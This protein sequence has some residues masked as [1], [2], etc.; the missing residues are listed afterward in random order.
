MVKMRGVIA[1]GLLTVSLVGWAKTPS[2]PAGV[3]QVTTVE[4]VTEY[5]LK[6]GLQVILA[7]DSSKPTTTVNI[8]Y[9]VGSRME[10]YGETGMA[11]LLEH[12][13]FKGTPKHPTIAADLSHR[14][15]RPNGTTWFDRTNYFE[16]FSASED[17]LSWALAMEAD[18]M[19]NS[20][21][22]RKDLDSEMTVVRNEM[23]KDE[24][25]ASGI[26]MDKLMATAY[27]WHNYGKS[28]IG[29]RTDVENVSIPHLQAFYHKYYQPDNATLVVA[30]SFD[31][32][33]TLALINK[34]FGSIPK[35]KRVIEP[36]YTLDPVQDGEREVTLRR[37]GDVKYV[38]AVYHSVAAAHPD[39]AAF[40]I[41][42]YIMG[43]TPSGRLHKALVEKGLATAVSA[44][45]FNLDEPGVIYFEA[46]LSKEQSLDKAKAAFIDTIE[47]IHEHPI[48][49]QEVE[50]AKANLLNDITQTFN[51]PESFGISLSTAIANG[52]WRLF[53]LNRDRIQ[54]ITTQDVERVAETWFKSSNRTLGEF[55]PTAKPDRVPYAT[56]VDAKEQLKGYTGNK[57]VSQAEAFDV[58][59][60]NI[61]KRTEWGTLASGV[62]YALLPKKT[63]GSTVFA[64]LNLHFGDANNLKDKSE[65]AKMVAGLLDRGTDK[66]TR[67]Q[68][69]DRF[70]E[71]KAQVSI[72]GGPTGVSVSVLTDRQHLADTLSLV[73]D[74]LRH[75]SFPES[76]FKQLQRAAIAT[77]EQERTD[78][79]AIAGNA[80]SRHFNHY[81]KGDVRYV[82]TF[83]E[84][85]T[86]V[87]AITLEQI[88]QFYHDFYGANRGEFAVVGDFDPQQIK[89]VLNKGLDQWS[90]AA[91][92]ELVLNEYQTPTALHEVINTPDKA[93][94]VFIMKLSLP[95][96][97]DDPSAPALKVANTIF[98]GGFLSSRLATRIRQK[99]GISYGV[100][101]FLRLN[102]KTKNSTLGAYAIYAPQNLSR[103]E[104]AFKEETDKALKDGFSET[105]VKEAKQSLRQSA[106]LG[107]AQDDAL[108]GLLT[109]LLFDNHDM[110][111]VEKMDNDLQQVSVAEANQ[112]FKKWVTP[113]SFAEVMAGDFNKHPAK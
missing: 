40:K 60:L 10:N 45:S 33:K 27:Q 85:E 7:P 73:T 48:T 58:S 53:F 104:Q 62:R 29:A 35:P 6:N 69:S 86:D 14:G 8:T 108:A 101:S 46:D 76:E 16:T 23:E 20:F 5:R 97:E 102:D 88:K 66:L 30:G 22:A 105:E 13:M 112:A 61:Q 36:T 70:T 81:P 50:R 103:L 72:T 52:D 51:D 79:Q 110:T 87:K 96:M 100:G 11:H 38:E 9:R 84:V 47:N 111:Y 4:G 109:K 75:S 91:H 113:A 54:K 25:D 64:Q 78:P 80:L 71:L 98:G 95:I 39:N 82:S 44:E 15:M 55:I 28:T 90:S 107:R 12:L 65:V 24:N 74:L 19:V 49:D 17:N 106:A 1:L 89:S 43:D 34:D 18:R 67:Q 57:I 63:R 93:N 56:R 99:E 37:V 21:I 83:D 92:Y 26:L 32:S 2:L 94:A 31:P 41:L 42:A 3:T 59:P 77:I 68:I